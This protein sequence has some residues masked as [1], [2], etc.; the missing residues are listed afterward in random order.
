MHIKC[1]SCVQDAKHAQTA[2]AAACEFR[3]AQ[4]YPSDARA[5]GDRRSFAC[6]CAPISRN[7]SAANERTPVSTRALRAATSS[8]LLPP[9]SAVCEA[10]TWSE[11]AALLASAEHEWRAISQTRSWPWEPSSSTSCRAEPR[12]DLRLVSTDEQTQRRMCA[13]VFDSCSTSS[14]A[15]S[16]DAAAAGGAA[17]LADTNLAVADADFDV[18]FCFVFLLIARLLSNQNRCQIR[19]RIGQGVTWKATAGIESIISASSSNLQAK[20]A[21]A[22]QNISLASGFCSGTYPTL[23]DSNRL[24]AVLR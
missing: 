24:E 10:A 20:Y 6:A 13:P 4:V 15:S 21:M 14:G 2:K 16:S 12:P 9:F 22:H 17:L 3:A 7:N 23:I 19:V 1:M 11:L 5:S 18:N 8:P